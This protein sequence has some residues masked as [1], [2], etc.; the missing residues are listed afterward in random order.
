MV[1]NLACRSYRGQ[2]PFAG[3]MPSGLKP[4][5]GSGNRLSSGGFCDIFEEQ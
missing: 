4:C 3:L 5:Y 1:K 2:T